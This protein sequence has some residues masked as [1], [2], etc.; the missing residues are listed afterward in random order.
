MTPKPYEYQEYPKWVKG[1]IVKN[2]VEED[3]LLGVTAPEP[4]ATVEVEFHPKEDDLTP[5]EELPK[6]VE[7]KPKRK[8]RLT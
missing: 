3:E 2:R 6:V 5:I 8:K 7:E 4:A 1:Q